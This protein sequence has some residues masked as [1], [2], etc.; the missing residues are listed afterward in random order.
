VN[1]A[2]FKVAHKLVTGSGSIKRL[3]DEVE[4]LKLQKPLIVTDSMLQKAGAVGQVADELGSIEFG[5]YAGVQPEPEIQLVAEC[6][7]QFKTNDHDGLIAVGGG[8]A[9][10]IAKAVSAVA[11]QDANIESLFGTD[12]VPAKGPP[13]IAIPT[14]AGTGSEVTN[15]A[16]LSD[17]R[18]QLKKGIVSDYILPDVAIVCPELTATM[19]K[20]VTAA[21]G[22]D[23]LVHGLEAYISLNASPITDALALGAIRMITA[24]LPLAY[25]EP[26]NLAARDSM[27]TGSLM[28]GM[29]FGSAGVGAVHA[30]AYPIGGRFNIAHGVSNALLLPYVMKWNRESCLEKFRDIAEAMGIDTHGLSSQEASTR[31]VSKMDS[32]C[33]QVEIPKGLSTIGIPES[34]LPEMAADAVKID[35]L[36]KNNP[37][38]LSEK[39][40]FDIYASAY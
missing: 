40:I 38:K 26:N 23:A 22:I 21:S 36:M 8:S 37:R 5:I 1:I 14:T 20:P 13:V 17:K 9:I 28:A 19:P 12:L 24:S 30:M 6:C 11:H 4:R 10:D 29:A 18:A 2:S 39:D 7:N 31:A 27:A 34:A 35:R 3:R 33:R 25:N 16:I 32:L 15:I